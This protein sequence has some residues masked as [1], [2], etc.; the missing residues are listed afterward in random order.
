MLRKKN[1]RK[2]YTNSAVRFLIFTM[3]TPTWLD[4]FQQRNI[5]ELHKAIISPS[6]AWPAFSTIYYTFKLPE[7]NVTAQNILQDQPYYVNKNVPLIELPPLT[8]SLIRQSLQWWE[9]TVN[10]RFIESDQH[11]PIYVFAFNEIKPTD[12]VMTNGYSNS[13]G[14]LKSSSTHA[15]G[16]NQ[17]ILPNYLPSLQSANFI[18]TMFHEEGHILSLRHPFDPPF[19]VTEKKF[20]LTNSTVM[21]Y[22]LAFNLDTERHIIPI[23][24]MPADID[25][26]QLMY[27]KNQSSHG[28]NDIYHLPDFVND[29]PIGYG[30][31]ASLPW[32][33]GG[34]DTLT[35]GTTYHDVILDIR[36]YGKSS[37]QYGTIMTPNIA[38]ENV[39]G[40]YGRNQI[41]LNALDNA[42]DVS[43]SQQT[44]LFVDARHTGKDT[45]TGFHPERDQIVLL[46]HT[47]S[48]SWK[49]KQISLPSDTQAPASSVTRNATIIEFDNQNSITLLDVNANQ[50]HSEVLK[51]DTVLTEKSQLDNTCQLSSDEKAIWEAVSSLPSQLTLD[52]LNAFATGS[53][54]TFLDAL[55]ED[56]LQ[57]YQ[58]HP[59][60]IYLAKTILQTFYILYTDAILTNTPGYLMSQ[61]LKF[62]DFSEDKAH[63]AG[64]L[65]TGVVHVAQNFTP[66]GI[67]RTFMNMTG[68]FA[69]SV[70]TLW[71]RDKIKTRLGI[72]NVS[73]E[74]NEIDLELGLKITQ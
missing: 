52:F 41:Y 50:L 65:V 5:C 21:A 32:D 4:D 12:G 35:A 7:D 71:A 68:G 56:I 54:L 60:N 66:L 16:F 72:A 19:A 26:V 23:T 20:N 45:V 74:E 25:A 18:D 38:V 8:Q 6:T 17:K 39:E 51:T 63:Q 30:T 40:G 22:N 11:Q 73:L 3:K 1:A 58:C 55:T 13:L 57:H 28:G 61:M 9:S 10:L 62:F 42:V 70:F 53:T 36:P 59:D 49:I 24:A 34:V 69:G 2:S 64:V 37:N 48:E 15:L 46:H 29:L 43:H 44:T 47:Q 33:A 27:G 14:T 31:I 67:A